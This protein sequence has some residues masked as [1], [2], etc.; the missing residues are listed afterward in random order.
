M[1]CR[2]F[3]LHIFHKTGGLDLQFLIYLFNMPPYNAMAD[4]YRQKKTNPV[5]PKPV[6]F[7]NCFQHILSLPHT[8]YLK[9][10]LYLKHIYSLTSSVSLNPIGS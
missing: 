2:V 5:L 7:S 1:K 6:G 8:V 4:N 3:D 10:E 9:N